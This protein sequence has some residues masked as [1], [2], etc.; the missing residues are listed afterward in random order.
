MADPTFSIKLNGAAY[1][2]WT[3][4]SISR[5][6]ERMSGTFDVGLTGRP[7]NTYIDNQL[8]PGTAVEVLINNAPVMIG[9]IDALKS[10]YDA[11]RADL[12]I[13]GRDKASDLID[14]AATVDGPFEYNGQK[15]DQILGEILKPY[16]IPVTYLADTGA[17][18]KRIAIQPGETAFEFIERLCRYRSLLPISDGLGGLLITKPGTEPSKGKL[19]YGQNILTGNISLD[20]TERFSLIVVKGQEEGSS[21]NS[22]SD[23][24]GA[25]GRAIDSLVTRYRPKV[26][27]G[28]NP[29]SSLSLAERAKWE[30]SKNRARSVA[31]S[32]KVQGWTTDGQDDL[33]KINTIVP[34][35][36]PVR[37]LSRDMLIKDVAFNRSSSGTTTNLELVLPEAFDLPAES[38]P[39]DDVLGGV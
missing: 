5:S 36:D 21:D 12:S 2:G 15:L 33:W 13:A 18:F 7:D 16:N 6:L 8:I 32:Y 31:A 37:G 3:E 24:A 19:V 22:A 23:V 1:T 25:E 27:T 35:V 39:D 20:N 14:C 26:I 29:D 10:S 11:N 17:A 30:V 28:E 34:V 9:Y 38:E 4:I